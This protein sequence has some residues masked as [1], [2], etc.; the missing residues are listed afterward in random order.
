MRKFV[1]NSDD[2]VGLLMTRTE[3][4]VAE[5]RGFQTFGTLEHP[6][7][8]VVMGNNITSTL[9]VH[10]PKLD[11]NIIVHAD[12]IVISAKGQCSDTTRTRQR[13][14]CNRMLEK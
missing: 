4:V 7:A 11:Q 2:V 10:F 12:T 14:C 13:C 6:W 8:F 1:L 9:D 3:N 5:N